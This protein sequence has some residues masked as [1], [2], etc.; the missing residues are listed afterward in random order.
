MPWTPLENNDRKS[1][2][3]KRLRGVW[4]L[5]QKKRSYE[6][7]ICA[8]THEEEDGKNGSVE[9]LQSRLLHEG[10]LLVEGP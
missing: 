5:I 10:P 1:Q 3:V 6:D 4:Y 8:V 2:W 9:V 7:Q